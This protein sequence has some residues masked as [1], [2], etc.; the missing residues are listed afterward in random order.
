MSN[1]ITGL[2]STLFEILQDVKSGKMDLDR[3]KVANDTAQ[4]I[5]NTAKAEVDYMRATGNT[6]DTD[7]IPQALCVPAGGRALPPGQPAGSRETA[8]GTATVQQIGAG[9]TVTTHR[10]K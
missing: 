9:A 4:T 2:R 10:M 3:A 7:F 8:H 6:T 1:D 5:I